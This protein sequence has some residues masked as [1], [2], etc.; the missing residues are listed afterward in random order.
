VHELDELITGCAAEALAIRTEMLRL[1]RRIT[2]ALRRPGHDSEEAH[3]LT[4]RRDRLAEDCS[5]LSELIRGL[6][7]R[8]KGL[9]ADPR[10][11]ARG[12]QAELG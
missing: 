8:R 10:G 3:A 12:S 9:S 11:P 1:D 7:E 5:Q 4:V 6:R 2:A